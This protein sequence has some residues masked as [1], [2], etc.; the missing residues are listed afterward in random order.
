MMPLFAN[1]LFLWLLP[2]AGLPVIFHL[3][4]RVKKRPRPFSTLMF[5]H[6]LDPRLS[7]R[8]QIKEWLI[9][10][11]RTLLIFLVLLA[12]ARPRWLAGGVGGSVS[13]V[14]ILD[15]SGS[16]SRRLKMLAEA[17]HALLTSLDRNDNAGIVLLVDDPTVSLPAGLSSDRAA[18]DAALNRLTET[19]ATGNVGAAL[20]R[21]FALLETS[22]A[23]RQEIHIFTDLQ[24]AE[25]ARTA[26]DL[27]GRAGVT[28]TVHRIRQTPMTEANIALTGVTLPQQR[29]LAGRPVTLRVGLRN[30][31]SLPARARLNITDDAGHQS[32]EEIVLGP[33]EEKELTLVRTVETAGFHWF[34]IGVDGD[35]FAADNRAGVACVVAEKSA[36]VFVGAPGDF[37]VLPVAISP[38]ADGRLSGLVPVFVSEAELPRA[39]T[40]RKPLLVVVGATFWSRFVEPVAAGRPLPQN[41]ADY[42]ERGGNVLI[43]PAAAGAETRAEGAPVVVLAKGAALFNDLRDDKGDV[44]LRSLKAFRFVPIGSGTPSRSAAG[45]GTGGSGSASATVLLGLEDGRALLTEQVI[46]QGR[47]FT[48]GIGFDATWS[49]LPLKGAFLALA[50][51]MALAGEDP[52]AA[53]ARLVAGSG[54]GIL[55]VHAVDRTTRGTPVLLHIRSLAG[56]PL[57]WKGKPVDAP[58]FPRAGVYAVEEN[59]RTTYVSIRASDRE[60][61]WKFV[62]GDALPALGGLKHTVRTYTTPESLARE[63]RV[64]NRG[65]DWYLPLLLLALA[66]LLVEGW[67]ANQ[68]PRKVAA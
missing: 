6:R 3:F 32:A 67:L 29:L 44:A 61:N 51:S 43:V 46:G 27:T 34:N 55:P 40:D 26:G 5:F 59:G 48:S 57:D 2:L 15:N 52:G 14:L 30:I 12:L 23:S 39:L 19:E 63:V 53:I 31:T 4:Y 54:T 21:A 33:E 9:L 38:A 68:P 42:V 58:A 18:L 49:T 60:G 66:A 20:R 1:P 25:W 37:G 28:I 47:V 41:L 11:L 16:M 64:I 13:T 22:H 8:K 35:G 36:V 45:D 24:E 10:I 7:A 17:A 65:A 56:S 62:T 50:Q